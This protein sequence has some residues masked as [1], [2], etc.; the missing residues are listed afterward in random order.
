MEVDERTGV[1]HVKRPTPSGL[2]AR[3][4]AESSVQDGAIESAHK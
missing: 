2:V 3:K 4:N 1:I